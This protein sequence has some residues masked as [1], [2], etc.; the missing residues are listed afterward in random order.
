[1]LVTLSDTTRNWLWAVFMPEVAMF[2]IK[3][4]DISDLLYR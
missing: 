4:S 2:I 1:M 3:P